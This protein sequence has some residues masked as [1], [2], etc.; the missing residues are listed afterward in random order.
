MLKETPRAA[1]RFNEGNKKVPSSNDSPTLS[2]LGIDKKVSSLA[3]K[4][5]NLT[6]EEIEKV[7]KGV[8]LVSTIKEHRRQ[9]IVEQAKEIEPPE[10][11]YRILY[12]DPPWCYGD[13]RD[14]RTTGAED[15]YTSMT[16][17]ELC[18]LPVRDIAEDNAV[19]FLWTTSPLLEACFS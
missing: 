19:L 17:E 13:K 10:G 18:N 3:Q 15:H 12:A 1:V 8:T 4:V 9:E 14:G 2:D 5:A 11:K 6:N 16:I 7:K